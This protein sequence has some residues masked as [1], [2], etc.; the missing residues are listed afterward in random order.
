[1]AYKRKFKSKSSGNN[2]ESSRV[3]GCAQPTLVVHLGRLAAAHNHDI[4]DVK[5][6]CVARVFLRRNLFQRAYLAIAQPSKHAVFCVRKPM[7]R[8]FARVRWKDTRSAPLQGENLGK[9][10]KKGSRSLERRSAS[11]RGDPGSES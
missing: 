1:M 8:T 7:R 11:L 6:G 9:H 10:A 3:V 4:L 5:R 2:S